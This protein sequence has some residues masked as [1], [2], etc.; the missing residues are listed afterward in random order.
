ML[1]H[2][3]PISA[4]V[5]LLLPYLDSEICPN[6]WAEFYI[7]PT[8]P[9]ILFLLAGQLTSPLIDCCLGVSELY[10]TRVLEQQPK[11]VRTRSSVSSGSSF[12]KWSEP[13]KALVVLCDP[14]SVV[15]FVICA[16]YRA[17]KPV[18]EWRKWRAMRRMRTSAK[19]N[20]HLSIISG[21]LLA[22]HSYWYLTW[23]PETMWTAYKIAGGINII[24]III[25]RD[26]SSQ[27]VWTCNSLRAVCTL[28]LVGGF[29]PPSVLRRGELSISFIQFNAVGKFHN[30][31]DLVIEIFDTPA[32]RTTYKSIKEE[33]L[34][35]SHL[36]LIVGHW[37]TFE[38]Y[39][40]YA[41]MYWL[42][43]TQDTIKNSIQMFPFSTKEPKAFS[44]GP[45]PFSSSMPNWYCAYRN[46]FIS[47][48]TMICDRVYHDQQARKEREYS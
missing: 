48:E 18:N 34:G 30:K 42:E 25:A 36:R 26:K 17:P 13:I 20:N 14:Q 11:Y 24:I 4:S 9:K 6:I 39:W 16:I 15:C 33:D 43:S 2:T 29:L 12:Q 3:S 19:D 7:W 31:I 27:F 5:V 1:G 46:S 23:S 32:T 22:D 35:N 47:M 41:N 10:M 21:S 38:P 40:D 44:R 45:L 28:L 37:S 8:V